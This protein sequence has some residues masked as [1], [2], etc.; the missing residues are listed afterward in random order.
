LFIE[1]SIRAYA[2]YHILEFVI[3]IIIPK[4]ETKKQDRTRRHDGGKL[5]Q[6]GVL[7][8]SDK[9]E[10]DKEERVEQTDKEKNEVESE[11]GKLDGVQVKKQGVKV[12]V[13]VPHEVEPQEATE[14]EATIEAFLANQNWL[15]V[16][17]IRHGVQ[18]LWFPKIT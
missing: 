14:V 9:L 16:Q 18:C 13:L 6:D 3:S 8:A 1:R 11:L 7:E 12:V 4:V 2:A 15:R 17:I 10:W 5:E